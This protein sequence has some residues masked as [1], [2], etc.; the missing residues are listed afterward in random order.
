MMGTLEWSR[1]QKENGLWSPVIGPKGQR[2]SP[3]EGL[4][5][6]DAESELYYYRAGTVEEARTAK[7]NA[8]GAF[9]REE[10][11]DQKCQA[12]KGWPAHKCCHDCKQRVGIKI[13]RDEECL[14]CDVRP[15]DRCCHECKR[16]LCNMHSLKAPKTDREGRM[17]RRDRGRETAAYGMNRNVL[18]L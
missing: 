5:D 3:S 15:T 1:Q 4:G 16:W 12:G 11:D 18:C 8:E 7:E 10:E 9:P 14:F 13:G 17:I 6:G 2:R